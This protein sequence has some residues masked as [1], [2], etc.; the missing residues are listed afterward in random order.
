ME[1]TRKAGRHPRFVVLD[2]PLTAYKEGDTT[3]VEDRDEVSR[4]L[5]YAFYRDI[6]ESY[7]DTQIIILE[8]KEP[9]DSI[10]SLVK[11]EHFTR[12]REKGRYGFFP[13]TG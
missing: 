6:A 13:V 1:M 8:N 10:I 2:S 5:V 12:N 7:P 11:Y 4:D 9:E 3:A